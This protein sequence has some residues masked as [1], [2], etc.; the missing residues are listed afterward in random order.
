MSETPDSNPAGRVEQLEAQLAQALEANQLQA[1]VIATYRQAL[2]NANH[3]NAVL[4]AKANLLQRR[5]TEAL[6]TEE[7]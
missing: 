5:T 7:P 1:Q 3:A 6:N 2:A 4:T